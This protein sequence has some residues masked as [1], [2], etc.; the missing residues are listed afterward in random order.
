MHYVLFTWEC[1]GN[2]YNK[3]A[4][5]LWLF[6]S[7]VVVWQMVLGTKVTRYGMVRYDT[8]RYLVFGRQNEG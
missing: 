6:L 2:G 8:V 3:N 1:F 5:T 4:K 7:S